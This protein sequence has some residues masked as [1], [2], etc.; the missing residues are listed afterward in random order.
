[1][2]RTW[3]M[4]ILVVALGAAAMSV[5]AGGPADGARPDTS[6][7][8]VPLEQILARYNARIERTLDAVDTLR[9]SQKMIE[10]QD[11]GT[12]KKAS[13]ILVYG[14]STGMVREEISSELSHPAGDYTLASL[15]GPRLDP[16][17]YAV[18]L[19]G[20]EEIEGHDCYRVAVTAIERDRHHIDGT[21]WISTTGFAPV[22]IVGE[23]SDPPFP[24]V[25][26]K[27][28]KSFES[29]EGGLWLLRRHTGEV[30]VSLMLAKKKG[31]R[32]IFYDDYTF[33]VGAVVDA[34]PE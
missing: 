26:I 24:L 33:S 27:L 4:F 10:P 2:K 16:A 19:T 7:V 28:D 8:S 5:G 6:R 32:H 34:L 25:M 13:A 3:H 22:R 31:L 20:T 18:E 11:D 21:V 17:E 29:R 14:R 12:R 9:V 1:V 23:V 15:I 30:E